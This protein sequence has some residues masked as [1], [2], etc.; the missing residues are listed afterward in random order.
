MAVQKSNFAQLAQFVS[1]AV[2]LLIGPSPLAAHIYQWE[3]VDPS[4]PSKGKKQSSVLTPGGAGAVA[5]PEAFL[6]QRDLTKAY[7][8]GANLQRARFGQSILIDAYIATANLTD[9]S[10]EGANLASADLTSANLR[11]ANLVNATLS[12]ANLTDANISEA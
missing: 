6:L 9:A 5:A 4:D 7:L 3:F 10:F 12:G 1:I 8:F 11:N 2:V